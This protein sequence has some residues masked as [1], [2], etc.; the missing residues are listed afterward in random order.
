MWY[1]L[2]LVALTIFTF[3]V[4]L[5][6]IHCALTNKIVLQSVSQTTNLVIAMGEVH[7]SNTHPALNLQRKK[8][9]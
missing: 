8:D 5:F 2:R 6:G 4:F 3:R 1:E 9:S 7:S